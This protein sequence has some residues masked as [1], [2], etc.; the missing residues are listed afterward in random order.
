MPADTFMAQHRPDQPELF[1]L[2]R[3]FQMH[4]LAAIIVVAAF[5]VHL[6]SPARR[7]QAISRTRHPS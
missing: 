2:V 7:R 6:R 4:L 3:I 5:G 1:R